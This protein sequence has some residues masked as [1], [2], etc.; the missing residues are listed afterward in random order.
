MDANAGTSAL[1]RR[2]PHSHPGV[3]AIAVQPQLA[4][5]QY[6]ASPSHHRRSHTSSSS[7]TGQAMQTAS[8]AGR[9]TATTHTKNQS[10]AAWPTSYSTAQPTGRSTTSAAAQSEAQSGMQ[11]GTQFEAQSWSNLPEQQRQAASLEQPSKAPQDSGDSDPPQLTRRAPRTLRQPPTVS[12]RQPSDSQSGASQ[13]AAAGQASVR[14]QGRRHG[15]PSTSA[16]SG[17]PPGFANPSS[18]GRTVVVSGFRKGSAGPQAKQ[19]TLDLCAEFGDVSCCWL[20]KGKSSCWFS[21]VQFAE[22]ST[23]GHLCLFKR[24][25]AIRFTLCM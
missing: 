4:P 22:V 11:P 17:H 25:F 12:S 14:G 23:P 21:I 16:Y 7:G 13:P 9:T 1:H 20:R 8:Q 19:L 3:K 18:D 10:A 15:S 6:Q 2:V 5:T 24:P